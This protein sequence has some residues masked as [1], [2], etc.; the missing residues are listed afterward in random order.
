[1]IYIYRIFISI[2]KIIMADITM[3]HADECNC[4]I[5][6]KCHRY[7]APV[8][9]YRQAYFSTPPNKSSDECDY[10]YNN[11]WKEECIG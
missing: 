8:N 10:F 6:D 5:K 11:E 1:M 7:T 4:A 3:C 2:R 9:E